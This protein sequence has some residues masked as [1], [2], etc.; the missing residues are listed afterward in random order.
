MRVQGLGI[1]A[2][3]D[4]VM[5][6][7][8]LQTLMLDFL[9]YKEYEPEYDAFTFDDQ[10]DDSLHASILASFTTMSSSSHEAPPSVPSS[11]YLNLKP[12]PNMLKYVFL[13]PNE[14]FPV[15]LAD[16]LN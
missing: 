9:L 2:K 15:I 5:Q 8:I 1:I 14:T 6:W 11:S 3:G 7:W 13:G 16:D 10:C 12:L 4:D